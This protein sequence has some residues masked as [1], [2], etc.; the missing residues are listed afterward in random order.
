MLYTYMIVS[1]SFA[2]ADQ[3][4][5]CSTATFSASGASCGQGGPDRTCKAAVAAA[6]AVREEA[7]T[8]VP[9]LSFRPPLDP[10]QAARNTVTAIVTASAAAARTRALMIACEACLQL[11]PGG[12]DTGFSCSLRLGRNVSAIE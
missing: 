2:Q 11:G 10:P 7:G 6:V 4:Q 3:V 12:V 9:E 5:R 8:G 1:A